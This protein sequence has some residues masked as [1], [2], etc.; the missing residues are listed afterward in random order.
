MSELVLDHCGKSTPSSNTRTHS[1]LA[2]L[3]TDRVHDQMK[4]EEI[5][6]DKQAGQNILNHL[7]N[8]S[9]LLLS[10]NNYIL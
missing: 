10:I 5:A 9:Q 1:H 2:Y 8:Y 3:H 4:S 6:L 7:N